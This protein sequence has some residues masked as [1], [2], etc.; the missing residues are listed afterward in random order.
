MGIRPEENILSPYQR[1]KRIF[2][3]LIL[4][5]TRKGL[6]VDQTGESHVELKCGAMMESKNEGGWNYFI[7]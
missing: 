2:S 7:I 5:P 1:K 4:L 3:A 6:Q